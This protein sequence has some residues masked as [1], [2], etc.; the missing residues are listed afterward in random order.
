MWVSLAAVWGGSL[1][2]FCPFTE[3][4]AASAGTD[5][6]LSVQALHSSFSPSAD[7]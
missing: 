2:L 3:D 4:A 6:Q 5:I 7:I 1:P